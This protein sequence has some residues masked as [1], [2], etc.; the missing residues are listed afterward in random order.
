GKK[1]SFSKSLLPSV[2][3]LVMIDT[4]RTAFRATLRPGVVPLSRVVIP[5]SARAGWLAAR[6]DATLAML[7]P[8]IIF[9]RSLFPTM[10]SRLRIG[11]LCAVVTLPLVAMQGCSE[12]NNPKPAEA[13]APPPPKQ[14]ELALPPKK[15]GKSSDPAE[16]PRYKK[17]M[18]SMKRA[19]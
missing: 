18:D 3:P 17:M 13:L 19:S 15:E 2:P 10:I 5:T 14:E 1:K 7:H 4:R 9:S 16:N 11:L 12:A 8:D 6:D